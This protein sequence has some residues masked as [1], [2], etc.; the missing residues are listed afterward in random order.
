MTHQQILNR[1][2]LYSLVCGAPLGI[3]TIILT[4][5]LPSGLT[6]D[7][8]FLMA[9]LPMNAV[10]I[11]ALT[12]SFIV[13]LWFAGRMAATCFLQGQKFFWVSVKYSF[14][15]NAIIWSVFIIT[16][17]IVNHSNYQWFFG[18]LVPLVL[19]I[20]CII[21]SPFTIGFVICLIIRQV[22][23]SKTSPNCEQP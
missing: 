4:L 15:V 23:L 14:F 18:I 3:F 17:A 10:P 11:I 9:F 13:S 8:L 7:G 12:V 16:F 6:G 2:G 21:I 20:S 5:I 19:F 1:S 22:T